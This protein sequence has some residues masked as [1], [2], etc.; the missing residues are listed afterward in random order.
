[1]Q[2]S[3][4]VLCVQP[5]MP[6]DRGVSEARRRFQAILLARGFRTFDHVSLVVGDDMTDTPALCAMCQ[7]ADDVVVADEQRRL[8]LVRRAALAGEMVRVDGRFWNHQVTAPAFHAAEREDSAPQ[9]VISER[10]AELRR[11]GE[12]AG[13]ITPFGPPD[14]SW[15][16]QPRRLASLTARWVLGRHTD[17]VRATL[18][19]AYR[20]VRPA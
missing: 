3:V 19:R 8:A 13:G 4:L 17:T 12:H 9:V 10:A 20:K 5:G 11:A 18:H 1:M 15:Y 14:W 7:L 2:A 6:L 16:E